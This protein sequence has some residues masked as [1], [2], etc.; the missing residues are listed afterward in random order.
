MNLN[1]KSVAAPGHGDGGWH[2]V[3]VEVIGPAA[4]DVHHNFVQ[5]LNEAC[6]RRLDDGTWG[7]DWGHDDKDDLG[8]PVQLS[9]PNGTVPV[10]MQRTIDAARYSDG[11]PSP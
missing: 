10:Q 5:R 7:H 1:P 11:S 3:Y 8:F 4:T 2:D 6:E 9:A